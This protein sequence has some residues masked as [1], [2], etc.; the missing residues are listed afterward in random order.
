MESQLCIRASSERA[1][2]EGGADWELE[3]CG[4]GD[5]DVDGDA[6]VPSDGR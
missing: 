6:G 2:F 5:E 4:D 1:L 3:V